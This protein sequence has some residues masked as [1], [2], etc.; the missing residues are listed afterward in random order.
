MLHVAL[1]RVDPEHLDELREWLATVN[2]PR[3][4]EALR[5]LEDEGCTHEQAFLL[6]GR[7]GPLLV[8]V[9]EVEDAER[10][11]AAAASSPHAIDADHRSVM[12]T[13]VGESVPAEMLLDLHF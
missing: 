4:D 3:R 5:T 8:Y 12:S 9:V 11:R 6:D 13:A 10:S 7:E 2:G 1:R